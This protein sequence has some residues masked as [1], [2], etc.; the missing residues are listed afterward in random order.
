MRI[1]LIGARG[2]LGTALRAELSAEVISPDRGQLNLNDPAVVRLAIEELKPNVVI[3]AAAYNL[4]DKAEDDPAEA[5]AVNA[6][7]VRNLAQSS[8]AVGA[9]LVHVST[10]YVFGLEPHSTPWQET[11]APGPAGVYGA[12][13]LTGEYFARSACSRHYVLR[14]CGLYGVAESA[15]KG[16]FIATML[17]LGKERGRISV[18]DD[19]H[20]TPTAAVDLARAIC[21][22]LPT[23]QYGLYHATNSGATTWCRLAIETFRLAGLA[24]EVQP[25]TTAQ[26]NAKAKR[27]AY[28]VLDCGKLAGVIG[29]PIPAWQDAVARYLRVR[30]DLA[31]A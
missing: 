3:N 29:A 31:G 17:R 22:I 28:S 9:T 18:V 24:V 2:Q 26:F 21:Q 11:D 20:C 6:F 27:P 30:G 8:E 19:Q 1:L 7:A 25:I 14:T 13:K 16:N 5:F 10:D 12:S 4:V 15:G 23:E